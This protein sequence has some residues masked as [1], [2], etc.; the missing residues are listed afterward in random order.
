MVD[1]IDEAIVATAK[2]EFLRH[3]YDGAAF[4]RIAR[5]LGVAP[6]TLYRFFKGKVELFVAVY[7]A[8]AADER[9]VLAKHLARRSAVPEI[10]EMSIERRTQGLPFRRS[11]R[12]L[13]HEEPQVRR[14]VAQARLA[15]MEMLKAWLGA[16]VEDEALAVDLL[17]FEQLAT[18]V[19]EGEFADLGLTEARA[20][21]RMTAIL[22]RWRIRAA[23]SN[24]D[25]VATQ[26]GVGGR[27]S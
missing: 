23:P 24:D 22:A 3:G 9:A 16:P 18:A 10:V 14:A 20:R 6:N 26:R 15:T 27:G 13:A 5:Q 4:A 21:E 2:R 12:W 17:L 25:A 8:W 1:L 19:A 7:E 11:V